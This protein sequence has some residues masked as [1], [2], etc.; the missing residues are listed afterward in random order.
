MILKDYIV[1]YLSVFFDFYSLQSNTPML[2]LNH[3]KAILAGEQ[4][5][6]T[7]DLYDYFFEYK[8]N[9]H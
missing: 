1:K 6:R 9:I 8:Y 5:S 2:C 4:E 3:N 7:S